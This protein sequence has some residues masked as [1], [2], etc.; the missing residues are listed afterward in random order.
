MLFRPLFLK[1]SLRCSQLGTAR[2]GVGPDFR[3]VGKHGPPGK[4]LDPWPFPALTNHQLGRTSTPPGLLLKEAL[5]DPVF[6]RVETDDDEPPSWPQPPRP[7][8]QPL[9]EG[10]EFVVDGDAQGLEGPPGRVG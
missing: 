6:Q 5:H 8:L 9:L 3:L 2:S 10:A 1:N 7:C 4:D